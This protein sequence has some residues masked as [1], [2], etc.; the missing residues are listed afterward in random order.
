RKRVNSAWSS[1]SEQYLDDDSISTEE[2]EIEPNIPS[3]L[4]ILMSTAR[5]SMD[6]AS[7]EDRDEIINLIEDIQDALTSGDVSKAKEIGQEL[8][9]IIFYLE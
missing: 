4:E 3:D 7:D 6:R 8:E 5:D 9:D 1:D 2:T